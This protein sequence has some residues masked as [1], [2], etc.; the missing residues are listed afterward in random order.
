[1]SR[2]EVVASVTGLQARHGRLAVAVGVFD[3]LHL[4]HAHLLRALV[5]HAATWRA[6]PAVVTFDAHPDA[7]LRGEA[8]PLLLD[9]SERERLL[10]EAGVEVIVVEH[11]DDRLR[12]TPFDAFVHAIASRVELAGFVMTPE[13]A[14]GYERRGTPDAVAALGAATIPPFAAAVV[15]PLRIGGRPVSSSEIRRFVAEGRLREAT[16]LL[17]R[18]YAI[19]GDYDPAT[20]TL[21]F[22]MPVALPPPG[23]YRAAV[24]SQSV[25][26]RVLPDGTVRLPSTAPQAG[27]LTVV[28][29]TL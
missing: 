21:R 28:F 12:T 10:G 16:A 11:F 24:A 5:D 1:M 26:V 29:D 8:P 15:E 4:G 7:V 18:P 2:P 14:F 20:G 13:T 25:V 6:R 22:G 27:R 17:G 9:P 23:D 3:G 19:E